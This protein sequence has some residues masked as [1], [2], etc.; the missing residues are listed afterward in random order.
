MEEN[1]TILIIDDD[2]E[3]RSMIS[4]VLEDEEYVVYQAENWDSAKIILQ[5]NVIN[6]VFLDLWIDED[7]YDGIIILERIKKKYPSIPVVMISG[8]GNI[9]IA[10][11]AIKYGAYD[12]IEKPFVI[13]RM[14]ITASRAIESATLKVE[15]T[16]LKRKKHGS[17]VVL[18][19]KST[20]SSKLRS[21][22]LKTAASSGSACIYSSYGGYAE[23]LA[24]LIHCNS[25]RKEKRFLCF[26][27]K[28]IDQE[29]VGRE[30]FG[31]SV[32][33]GLI[34]NANGG[35][36][37]LDNIFNLNQK[38]QDTLSSFI[39]TGKINNISSDTRIIGNCYENKQAI[40]DRNLSLA[41]RLSG[42]E[43]DIKPL[44]ERFMDVSDIIDYYYRNSAQIFGISSPAKL[45]ESAMEFLTSYE[46]SGNIVQLK[47]TLEI[48]FTTV[49]ER[50]ID[51]SDLPMVGKCNDD[52]TKFQHYM[53]LPIKEARDLFDK[54]YI[55]FQLNKF[56]YNISQIARNID[57]DR[58]AFYKKLKSLNIDIEKEINQ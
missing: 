35:T 11:K 16:S 20:N 27:C 46:W 42:F 49:H 51:I 40:A 50:D 25:S 53:N 14:L 8:H 12:F 13:E 19:G 5:E 18:I 15:N 47:D 55:M 6:L 45:S 43:L 57:M 29:Y 32:N 31:S 26:D 23:D 39:Q 56:D 38:N 37:F 4:D 2:T 41:H 1:K 34:R 9:E 52:A 44:N 28:I 17:D 21:Q 58:S 24:W 48:L 30:L 22:A 54:D 7:E 33:R 3:V 36:I 10:V